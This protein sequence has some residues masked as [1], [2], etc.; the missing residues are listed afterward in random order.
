MTLSGQ[1][2][3]GNFAV[4]YDGSGGTLIEVVNPP[5]PPVTTA[6]M[7][8]RDGNNGDFEIYDLGNNTIQAAY[9]LI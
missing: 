9:A 1:Y 2:S 6:D 5:P 3:S 8:M 7:I 4:A